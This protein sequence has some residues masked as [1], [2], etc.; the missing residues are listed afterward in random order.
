MYK[1]QP[2]YDPW[3]CFPTSTMVFPTV[4]AYY[5]VFYVKFS[6]V[7]IQGIEL[8]TRLSLL[9]CLAT[10]NYFSSHVTSWST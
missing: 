1:R 9:L 6:P 2:N 8:Q 7:G 10:N 3:R 5:M 4:V